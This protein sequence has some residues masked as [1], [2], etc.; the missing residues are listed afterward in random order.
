MDDISSSAFRLFVQWLYTQNFDLQQLQGRAEADALAPTAV[1]VEDLSIVELWVLA[2]KLLIPTLQNKAIE[3][4]VKIGELT[5]IAAYP[6]FNWIYAHTEDRNHPLRR[7][8]VRQCTQIVPPSIFIDEK[9]RFPKDLLVEFASR[10]VEDGTTFRKVN[11]EQFFVPTEED[12]RV[13]DREPSTY[14]SEIRKAQF[15]NTFMADTE[16]PFSQGQNASVIISSREIEADHQ[17]KSLAKPLLDLCRKFAGFEIGEMVFASAFPE[18]Q[19]KEIE[20][21]HNLS[22]SLWAKVD[23]PDETCFN[24]ALKY[25]SYLEGKQIKV[26]PYRPSNVG[27]TDEITKDDKSSLDIDLITSVQNMHEAFAKMKVND[28]MSMDDSNVNLDEMEM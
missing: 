7:L 18:N 6:T 3:A 12:T 19:R 21:Q 24:L 13:L 26:Q 5:A 10:L 15:E 28:I 22:S 9:D 8:A 16:A 4:I 2:E 17:I 23:F 25:A 11:S 14:D 1:Y 27:N 20:R